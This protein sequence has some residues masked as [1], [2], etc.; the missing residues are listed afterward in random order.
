MS[1]YLETIEEKALNYLGQISNP[2]VRIDVLHAH[3]RDDEENA[4][5]TFTDL[6]DFLSRHDSFRVMEAPHTDDDAASTLSI[7][8]DS[9]TSAFVILSTRVPTDKQLSDMM[10][11]Q[12]ESMHDALNVAMTQAHDSDDKALMKKVGDA[13]QRLETLRRKLTPSS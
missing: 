6:K 2:L 11:D 12:L 9:V 1:N 10:L 13:L 5:L 4:P 8:A 7:R 3:L